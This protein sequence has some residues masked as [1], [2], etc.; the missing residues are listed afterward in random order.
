LIRTNCGITTPLHNAF[1]FG[2]MGIARDD[3]RI[4]D[5]PKCVGNRDFYKSFIPEYQTP[6][7]QKKNTASW[8]YCLQKQDNNIYHSM[9]QPSD[10]QRVFC[11][12]IQITIKGFSLA[13][14]SEYT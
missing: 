8:I 3:G 2:Q 12:Y 1:E 5:T 9:M 4:F 10:L 14:C 6:D 13:F 7:E 11:E